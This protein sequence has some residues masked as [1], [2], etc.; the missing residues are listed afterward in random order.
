MT[1]LK[2]TVLREGKTDMGES[3]K[4]K[5]LKAL[6]IAALSALA[7]F[8]FTGCGNAT[9]EGAG[10]TGSS[11]G[12][13]G[14][15]TGTGTGG[16]GE[17]TVV[18]VACRND[19]QEI[20]DAVN[21][22]LASEGIKVVNTAY[23]T[24]V[25]LNELLVEGDIEMNVAQ[26]YAAMEYVKASDPKFEGLTAIGEI[27]IATL[28]LYSNKYASLNELPSGA[29]IA[30]PNDLM[31][32]GR[33]LNVLA[34]SGLITLKSG[35]PALPTVEDIA[36]NPKNIVFQDIASDMMVRVLDDV[37][38]GFV[39]SVN[40]VDGGLDPKSDPIYSDS[41]DFT[42]NP[43]ERQF[44]IIFTVRAEDANNA[45]YQKVVEAYH[46]RRV[47]EAYRDVYG[48]SL[49]PIVDGRAIDVNAL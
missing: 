6:V 5:L 48:V 26:H 4:R 38:A 20:W 37:D 34:T 39:Y 7:L 12:T 18:N 27:H 19:Y 32:G 11:G 31:N 2:E 10:G 14:G 1:P 22:E 24:S 3:G 29:T 25:N 17:V 49:I 16:T 46:S 42:Q 15:G 47:Q 43:N 23:D 8:A 13:G 44:I 21:E 33:A 36:D 35:A 9:D 41:V 40:A 30:I 45:V 28:D